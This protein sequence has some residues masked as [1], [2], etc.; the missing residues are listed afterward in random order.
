LLEST[1]TATRPFAA[2]VGL[3]TSNALTIPLLR[4]R[5][6]I[7][8]DE[9]RVRSVLPLGVALPSLLRSFAEPSEADTLVSAFADRAREAVSAGC[10]I[11]VPASGMVAELLA[12]RLGKTA[13][14]DLGAGAPI[15]NPVFLAVAVAATAAGLAAVGLTTSRAGTYAAPPADA[16]DAFFRGS[17]TER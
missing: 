8:G 14:W 7:Y 1:L 9:R 12:A 11:I 15:V 4:E 3:V 2:T 6:L 10:E 13:A 16:L 5:I 17:R